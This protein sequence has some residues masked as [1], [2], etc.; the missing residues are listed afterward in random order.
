M[1]L[2]TAKCEFSDFYFSPCYF[3]ILEFLSRSLYNSL[4][5]VANSPHFFATSQVHPPPKQSKSLIYCI[6]FVRTFQRLMISWF[7]EAKFS[8]REWFQLWDKFTQCIFSKSK[9]KMMRLSFFSPIF[10]FF[11]TFDWR[12]ILHFKMKCYYR[13]S[14]IFAWFF[15]LP[16]LSSSSSRKSTENEKIQEIKGLVLN[17]WAWKHVQW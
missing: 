15:S 14:F 11:F 10:K 5:L 3:L 16:F 6:I 13:M 17:P 1:V 7:I 2:N 9:E 4:Q 12:N 8:N